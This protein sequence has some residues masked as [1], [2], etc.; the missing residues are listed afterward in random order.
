MP[1][2]YLVT[3]GDGSLDPGDAI[4]GGAISFTADGGFPSGLGAGQWTWSG[5]A[6]GSAYTNEV[7]PGQYW[8]ADDG[9]VYFVPKLGSVDFVTTASTTTAPTYSASGDGIVT[10][11]SGD[12]VIVGGYTDSDGDAVDGGDGTG[13][14]GHE[15]VVSAG[16]G[17]DSIEAGLENDTVY[18]GS[19][20]DTIDGGS[21][22]DV[23]Y[24]DTDP[25]EAVAAPISINTS[26]YTDTSTG[27]TVTAQ[28]VVGGTLTSASVS[29]IGTF[30]G[31]FGA[32]GSVSDTDSGVN[33]QIGY[34]LA[35][36]LSETLIVDIDAPIDEL[37]FT[38]LSLLTD[39]FGEV[40]HYA[41]YSGGTLVYETDFT[42]STGT[43]NDTITVSGHGD[44]DHIVFTAQIQTDLTDGS[45]YGISDI[46]F[47]P[48]LP[49]PAP[50]D[51]SI[52][53]GD[54]NDL[55]YGEAGADTLTG[56][57]G[58]D[59]LVGGIGNDTLSGGTGDDEITTGSGDDLVVI[60]QFGANDTV[61]D[62]DISDTDADGNS[63]D[64]LDVSDLR[65]LN[66]NPVNT[67]DVVVTDDGSGNA[68]LT[69]PEG[70][71][72][73]FQGI[74]PAQM[75]SQQ[76]TASGIPCYAPATLIDT[77][78]GPR[79][80]ETLK[81]GDLV[82]TLD[83]GPQPIRWTRS[84]EY[85][86]EDA[87]ADDTPV[88]IKAGAFGA[89]LP[90]RDLIV[91]PQHRIFVGGAGQLQEEFTAEALA[92]AKSLTALPGIRHMKGKTKIRWIH[93]AC[94]RHEVVTAN[95]C[96]SES[97][98]IGS[99]VMKGLTTLERQALTDI[100]GATPTHDT[101]LNGPAARECLKVGQVRRRLAKSFKEIGPLVA[102][103]IREWDVDLATERWSRE[104]GPVV[105]LDQL[106]KEMI[107]N[108]EEKEPLSRLQCQ[109]F[110]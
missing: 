103:E 101:V 3:L 40:G 106:V 91:S 67:W 7:E 54:G 107:P 94:D 73:T 1:T 85:P 30:S 53:G 80:V 10:G 11:T 36:G 44:F 13:A 95:G 59:T 19:G 108:D 81:P 20:D 62:F 18:G 105:K 61:Y 17:N 57:A 32:N 55:I 109:G 60:E 24:G 86:L 38:T 70:E 49:D 22:N 43:G 39:A 52:D 33:Q 89:S 51:D 100:F 76:M 68:L 45:D 12:D 75:T 25:N 47:T 110:G 74:S 65:D 4:S 99:E 6:G 96:L 37:T 63:N 84:S 82:E 97:L 29:N 72:L 27:F 69:F 90:A 2:G 77:P 26:N 83:H 34:D 64:Q 93:F 92:P 42:D 50:G 102:K 5:E 21:G 16:M 35:S 28:N 23:L 98:L 88:L 78:N 31:S 79:A 14:L 46:T 8:L 58:N 66:G 104:F 9:N 48:S 87:K 41:I 71:T 15:D 56:G